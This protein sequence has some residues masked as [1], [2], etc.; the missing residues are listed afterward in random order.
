[1]RYLACV[2]LCVF[3][4]F[5]VYSKINPTK[6]NIELSVEAEVN[7]NAIGKLTLTVTPE[8]NLLLNWNELEPIFDQFLY[9]ENIT[10]MSRSV[11]SELISTRDLEDFGLNFVFDLS[12]FSLRVSLPSRLIKPQ[13]LSLSSNVRAFDSIHESDFSG[14][15]NVYSSYFH[16]D[17]FSSSEN[18][19]QSG[20]RTEMVINIKKWVLENESE[21]DSNR[22]ENTPILKRLG[23][24]LVHDIPD[25]GLRITLGDNNTTGSYFQSSSNILGLAISHNYSLVSDNI[26]R[27]SASR[28]FTLE[29]P[30]T[31]EVLLDDQVIQRLNL[32]SGIYLLDDIP[33]REGNNNIT[34]KITDNV[35]KVSIVNFDVT[36]GLNLFA[37]GDLKYEVFFGVPS[38]VGENKEYNY[39]DP[40]ITGYLDYGVTTGWTVGLNAQADEYVQQLGFKNIVATK[41]GQFA[42]ENSWSISDELSGNAYRI[43]YSTFTDPSIEHKSFTLGYEH[44]SQ[45]YSFLGYRPN[46]GNNFQRREHIFQA[47]YSYFNNPNFQTSLFTNAST[48]YGREGVDKAIGFSF[49]HDNGQWRYNF[50]GQWEDD[51]DQ[52]GWSAK[53]SLLYKFSNNQRARLSQ[54][55]GGKR[56]RIEFMQ[57]SNRRYVDSFNYR[58]GAEKNDQ[59]EAELD[60]YG[61]YNS[62]RF[63]TSFDHSS[64][65]EELNI[66]SADHQTRLSFSSSIAFAGGDWT[67]GKPI[68]DSFALVKAHPSLDDKKI[69]LGKYNDQYR[70]SNEDFSTI[71]LN[72]INSYSR[73]T[74]SVDVDNLAL[75]YDIGSGVISFYPSYRSGHQVVIGTEANISVIA[76]LL[77]DQNT[78]LSL[79]VGTAVCTTDRKK[80][81]KEFFTN[82]KGKFALTGLVP[83]QYEITL[84]NDK[85]SKFLIDVKENEQLQ[86]KGVIY[87][88]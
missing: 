62:N 85:Q 84:K 14:Y 75:G 36:T 61:Q 78:P 15:M 64:S 23:T 88:H 38:E 29:T 52:E 12:D 17:S 19:N 40:L 27:P 28:S 81:G 33:L 13:N 83:C 71:L 6:R 60:L 39:D 20:V 37:E 21:Y 80:I 63:L 9:L 16:Q 51:N 82:K 65:Y 87:V 44:S 73:S 86:R 47:N 50:G 8:D 41:I 59:D 57:D 34:L 72:D 70:A 45:Y 18:Y 43:V 25:S 66:Q 56:T 55:S 76:T 4:S 68:Y 49:T 11:S 54:Q 10:Q 77:D 48:S 35:G 26:I 67:V 31:V 3:I 79:Q 53:F 7:K 42:F 22:S 24:R 69:T 30:S 32:D 74:V 1:M 2:F 58:I 5:P 46:Q